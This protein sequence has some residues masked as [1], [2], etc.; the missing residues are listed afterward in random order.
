M[1]LLKKYA[2]SFH[3]S[4]AFIILLVNRQ[5]LLDFLKQSKI[6]PVHSL[7]ALVQIKLS[8][9][10]MTEHF[11]QEIYSL[12]KYFAKF[13]NLASRTLYCDAMESLSL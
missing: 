6:F 11:L 4:L 12:S 5:N 2:Y 7:L 9:I 8:S 3:H 13:Y 10:K 1:F